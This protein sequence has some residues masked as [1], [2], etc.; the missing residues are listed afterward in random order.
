MYSVEESCNLGW[1]DWFV[2]HLCL[3][4]DKRVFNFVLEVKSY[5]NCV[6]P[7]C[8]CWWINKIQAYVAVGLHV[9]SIIL[10]VYNASFI[11][12]QQH[13]QALH[14][15]IPPPS[16][17]LIVLHVIFLSMEKRNKWLIVC[18][19]CRFRNTTIQG[20]EGYRWLGVITL[21]EFYSLTHPRSHMCPFRGIHKTK[22]E[23]R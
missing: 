10:V 2:K 14:F 22:L 16:C 19:P 9:Y 13:L 18:S 17:C 20:Q 15:I 21:C 7:N 3:Y 4:N 12:G 1:N 23:F 8:K 11:K 6:F 5:V